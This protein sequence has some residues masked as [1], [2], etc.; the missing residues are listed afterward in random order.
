MGLSAESANPGG[1]ADRLRFLLLNF[2]RSAARV[3]GAYEQPEHTKNLNGLDYVLVL[4]KRRFVVFT[5]V[6]ICML[7]GLLVGFFLP[8]MYRVTVLMVPSSND[9]QPPLASGALADLSF[10]TGKSGNERKSEALA[11]L[12]ARNTLQRFIV[13]HN[14]LPQLYP[15][16]WDWKSHTWKAGVTPP[17]LES[18]YLKLRGAMMIEDDS[19]NDLIRLRV[20]WND[21]QMAANWANNLVR[22]VNYTM[23]QR[24]VERANKRIA[25]LYVELSKTENQ[26]LH[27]NIANLIEQQI[28]DR[29]LANSNDQFALEVV[30]P[31]LPTKQKS[32]VG[33][34]ITMI[35]GLFAGL[36]IGIPLAFFRQAIDS[37]RYAWDTASS[38]TT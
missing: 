3:L 18:A 13:T 24:E 27:T 19:A 20:T 36:M 4:Y 5:T 7:F 9:T 25:A 38:D 23:Q 37:L 1:I 28:R 21:A 35:A 17:T 32:S 8:V 31:A 22:E 15:K 26:E 34:L 6:A 29:I 33:E 14:L 12:G 30:D 2:L 11:F 10:L 16:D